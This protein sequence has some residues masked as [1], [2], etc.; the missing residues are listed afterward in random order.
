MTD[1]KN[2]E[3]INE[4]Y[5]DLAES[6]C[7]LSCGGAINHGDA[8][9]GEIC[10]DLGSGRGLE[11]LKL[12]DQ[13][14]SE[15]YVY[16]LDISDGMLK[17][18]KS[19]AK[20]LGIENVEFVKTTLEKLPLESDLVDLVIS[21]CTINHASNKVAVWSEIYRILKPDGRFVVS[22]IYS[23]EKVPAE[24]ATDP[25]AR[26]ECWAGS[27]TK[28]VYLSTLEFIGFKNIKIIEESKP[29]PKGKIEVS[30]FTIA[31]SKKEC[32]TI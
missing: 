21:N 2:I 7:C 24:Y 31:G 19:S 10:A 25:D 6:D 15:G 32:C 29:Y 16:G 26:A 18:A 12:A 3:S 28:E 9:L 17:K 13:V 27:V 1:T 20:K 8:K 14:G 4:R 22:D 23:S 5:S 30:S 11:V